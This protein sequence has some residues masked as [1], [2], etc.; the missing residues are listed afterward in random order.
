MGLVS[1]VSAS[2]SMHL[3]GPDVDGGRKVT[4]WRRLKMDP[5]H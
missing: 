5:G 3:T 4:H 2:A 1:P